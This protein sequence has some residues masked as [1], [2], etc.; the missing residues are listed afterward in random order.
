MSSIETALANISLCDMEREPAPAHGATQPM[1]EMRRAEI[2]GTLAPEP[3]LQSNPSRFVLF[4]IQDDEIWQMY[5]NAEASFW[6]AEELDLVRNATSCVA[7]G[8]I[9]SFCFDCSSHGQ[10]CNIAVLCC[11]CT[12]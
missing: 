3:L 8:R 7:C 12:I 2:A 11:R 1:T 6:T 4:P 10:S 5:K 9:D